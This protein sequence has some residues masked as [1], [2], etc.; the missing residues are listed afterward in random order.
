[1]ALWSI[2]RQLEKQMQLQT[3]RF[4]MAPRTVPAQRWETEGKTRRAAVRRKV[5]YEFRNNIPPYFFY[6]TRVRSLAMLVT[7]S[8]TH[9]LTDPLTDS[10]LFS[11]LDWCD[12][13]VWRY[14]LKTCY[15]TWV[16][17]LVM[18]VSNWLTHWLTDSLTH[19]CLVNLMALYDPNCLM[20]TQQLRVDNSLAEGEV[21]S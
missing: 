4:A 21:W 1:M 2:H 14:Q 19:S 5:G 8:L 13:G 18:L 11:K 10:L 16:R 15:R 17:S 6:R 20:M 9:S 12:P 7:H 3:P